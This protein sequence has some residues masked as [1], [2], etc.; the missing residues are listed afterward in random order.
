MFVGAKTEFGE[1]EK[2][3]QFWFGQK[4][5]LC[6]ALTPR[7]SAAALGKATVFIGHDGGPMHLAATVGTPCVAIFSAR[8]KP[9]TWF[10]FGSGHRVIYHKTECYGCGLDVCELQKK[11][12]ITSIRVDEVMAAVHELLN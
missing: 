2:I 12:C 9:G 5:N 3:G 10:P 4:V 11:K 6:G 8:N 1:S 7:E